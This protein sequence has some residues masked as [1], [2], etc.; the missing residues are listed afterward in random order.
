MIKQKIL[1]TIL[2]GLIA[3]STA[4]A[5]RQTFPLPYGIKNGYYWISTLWL[6]DIDGDTLRHKYYQVIVVNGEP[7]K[8][9]PT[10]ILVDDSMDSLSMSFYNSPEAQL[11]YNT[12]VPG[13]IDLQFTVQEAE[14]D[15]QDLAVQYN[16]RVMIR[17]FN[18]DTIAEATHY[19]E[20]EIWECTPGLHRWYSVEDLF[21]EWIPI[22]Q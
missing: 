20:T 6:N 15:P 2:T 16:E 7:D 4:M 21:G 8:V 17:L 22:E 1:L 13:F 19:R 14:I 11:N 3:F 18:G 12:H 10:G 9:V 5:D